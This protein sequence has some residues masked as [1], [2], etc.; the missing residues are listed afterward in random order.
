MIGLMLFAWAK[1]SQQRSG[2]YPRRGRAPD[3]GEAGLAANFE[4]SLAI[5]NC[6]QRQQVLILHN[7]DHGH[8][9]AIEFPGTGLRLSAQSGEAEWSGFQPQ[10]HATEYLVTRR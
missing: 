7:H 9:C 1:Y 3:V 10:V 6:L 8:L 2:G 4:V 5:V